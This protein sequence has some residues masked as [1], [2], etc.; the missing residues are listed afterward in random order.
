METIAKTAA[1]PQQETKRAPE[2]RRLCHHYEALLNLIVVI[3]QY[4]NDD[5]EPASNLEP[6]LLGSLAESLFDLDEKGVKEKIRAMVTHASQEA[7]KAGYTPSQIEDANF[8]IIA[9]IDE[10]IAFSRWEG[11]TSWVTSKLQVEYFDRFDAG[12]EFFARLERLLEAPRQNQ[13]VLELYYLC[14]GIGFKG[15]NYAN[16]DKLHSLKYD[17]FRKLEPL[18]GYSD[19]SLSVNKATSNPKFEVVREVHSWLIFGIGAALILILWILAYRS[20]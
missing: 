7:D 3:R 9:F 13:D 6:S 20:A 1:V 14:L 16:P 12:K 4:S 8:A 15:E 19:R 17:A 5:E 11:K 18:T 2:K 10:A